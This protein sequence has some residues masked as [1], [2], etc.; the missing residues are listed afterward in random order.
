MT[1]EPAPRLTQTALGGGCACKMGPGDLTDALLGLAATP[2]PRVMVGWQDGDDAGVF[3][4]GDEVALIQTVDVITPIVDDPYLF[5]QV[6]AANALSDIY[7]TGGVPLTALNL[8]FWP[9]GAMEP[10]VLQDILRGGMDKLE[11]AGV[12][13]LGGH[14]VYDTDLKYGLSVTGTAHPDRVL[15][16]AGARPGDSLLLTKPLG[17]GIISQALKMD[18][19]DGA[20]VEAMARSMVTLNR[21]A[22]GLMEAAEVHACT[23]ISGFGLLGHAAEMAERSGH[24]IALHSRRVPFLPQAEA[25]ARK[26]A[27]PAGTERNLEFRPE[28]IEAEGILEYLMAL[29]GDP[30]TSGGLLISL[31]PAEA[32]RLLKEL[33]EHGV[34]E[35]ALVGEVLPEPRGKLLVR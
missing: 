30:Q 28:R 32:D 2:D 19:A 3:R 14:S 16:R 23:D 7:A 11:E 26:G 15:T 18:M 24:C 8:V 12:S 17:T 22:G 13:L 10:S 29:L 9:V 35:A 34:P 21:V 25:L 4:L 6:A 20:A 27:I 31:P 33:H 5:G 1:D